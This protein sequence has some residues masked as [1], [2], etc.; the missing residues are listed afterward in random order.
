VAILGINAFHGDSSAAVFEDGQ[1]AAAIEEERINRIKHW[2]GFPAHAIS[3]CLGAID[4]R[5]LTDVAISRDPKAHFGAKLMRAAVSPTGWPRLMSRSKNSW[6][7]AQ[8]PALFEQNEIDVPK[9][10]RYHNVEHHRT[11]MASAFFCSPFEEAAILSVDGFGD[12]SSVMWGV[13]RGN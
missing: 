7:V 12:F 2:A 9:G 4:S 1:L 6:R 13:G 5:E 3:H 10:V 8:L 11:H